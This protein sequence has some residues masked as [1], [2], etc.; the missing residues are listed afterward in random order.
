MTRR[1]SWV[2]SFLAASIL[3]DTA[4]RADEANAE[5]AAAR[6][7]KRFAI[8]FNTGYGGDHLPQDLAHFEKLV[9]GAKQA[10]FNTVLGQYSTARAKVLKLH[11]V[12]IFVDLLA[13]EHYVYNNPAGA[14]K[15]CES[16]RG[17]PLVYAYHLWSDNIAETFAGRS[18]DVATVHGWDPTHPAYVGTYRMSRVNRVEGLDLLG[19]YDFHWKR[20]GH[21]EHLARAWEVARSKDAYFLRYCDAAPG[22]VGK[23]NPNRVGYTI[24]TSVVFGLKGYLFHYTGGVVDPRTG[25]LDALGKDLAAV[26][27]RF[28]AI[29]DELMVIGNPSAVYSTPI[30]RDAKDDPVAGEPAVP[31]G[32][33]GVPADHWFQVARGEVLF[34][35]F[36]AGAVEPEPGDG[37]R[38]R[39]VVVLA[40]HNAYKPQDVELVFA[41]PPKKVE[42]FDRARRRWR[43]L[44]VDGRA[45]RFQVEVAAAELVRV[46]R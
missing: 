30:T 12:R 17:D 15:L 29:G 43:P 22:Q 35:L 33:A 20:G 14:Q 34:G 23:G 8:V 45:A 3:A 7:P 24:A 4:A 27:A 10:H 46:A 5:A 11:R 44:K 2:L 36:R 40:S 32:L 31:A 28:E 6:R 19:Y 18:R 38:A 1:H 16:L 21:W 26:N 42:L 9:R 39:D 13:T 25:E 41:G 37:E